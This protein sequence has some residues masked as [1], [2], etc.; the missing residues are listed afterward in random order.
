MVRCALAHELF[1][2]FSTVFSSHHVSIPLLIVFFDTDISTSSRRWLDV[3]KLFFLTVG[4]TL[5]SELAFFSMQFDSV[6][7]MWLQIFLIPQ[8][9]NLQD[10]IRGHCKAD[11]HDFSTFVSGVILMGV[12]IRNLSII[13]YSGTIH[14][15]DCF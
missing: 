9:I 11:A 12:T 3:G 5:L 13:V 6:S 4:V 8:R 2:S 10:K 7:F 1:L 15:D 14:K